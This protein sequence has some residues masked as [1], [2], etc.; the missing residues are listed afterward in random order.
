MSTQTIK[1]TF[2]KW[3]SFFWPIHSFELK[4]LLPMFGLFFLFSF[5]YSLLKDTKEPLLITAPGSGAEVIPFLKV[6]LILPLAI[7]FMILFAK[8]SNHLRKQT[9]FYGTVSIFIGFFALFAFVL[10]PLKDVIHPTGFADRLQAYLPQGFNGLVGIFRNWSFALFYAFAELWGSMGISLLFWGFANDI[11][12]ISE[13]KRFYSLFGLGTSIAM[14]CAGPTI[15]FLTNI[16]NKLPSGVDSWGISL[17]NILMIIIGCGLLIMGLYWWINRYVLTDNRFFQK[18]E[19]ARI[20][21]EKPKLSLKEAFLF[22]AKSKH[23][24]YLALL[25]IGYTTTISVMEIIWKSQLK[26]AF[27]HPNDYSMFRG[28]FTTVTSIISLLMMFFVGSNM[29]RRLGWKV[30]ALFTP[31][32][33]FF[34][35]TGFFICIIY[36]EP[37]SGLLKGFGVTPVILAVSLGAIQ[38]CLSKAAKVALYEPTKEMAYIPLDV[39]SKVKGKAAIDVIIQKIG[40][41]GAGLL[42]QSF[43]VIF[44]SVIATTPYIGGFILIIVL[45]WIYGANALGKQFETETAKEKLA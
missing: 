4:K 24:R 44:G 1:K 18:A 33:M 37:L 30:G 36:R 39:E 21:K 13:S 22:L 20:K 2:G 9:L 27:P 29:I 41:G 25:V 10:Y 11:T 34:T 38:L 42:Q 3:R 5:N 16:R 28:Y 26:L 19:E 32:L 12:R 15:I 45:G 7:L 8:L 6:W 35:G 14:L 17:K 31:I 43:I 23:M 40:K